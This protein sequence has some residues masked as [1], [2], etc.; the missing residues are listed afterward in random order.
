MYLTMLALH[1][2]LRWLVLGAGLIAVVR[3]AA[4]LSGRPFTATDSAAARWFVVSLDVQVLVGLILYGALSP[5]TA[6]ALRDMGSAMSQPLLRYW[7]VEHLTGMIVA[8]ALAHIG[9]ARIR[10][11]TTDP[12]RHRAALVFFG[13]ALLIMLIAIPWPGLRAGRPLFPGL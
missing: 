3:A 4:G 6:T 5:L 2:V 1:S 12:A 8:L 11:G 7:A 13:L 9:R 10:K